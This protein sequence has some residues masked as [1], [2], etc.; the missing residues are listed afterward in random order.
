VHKKSV[1][2]KKTVMETVTSVSGISISS[3]SVALECVTVSNE[4]PGVRVEPSANDSYQSLNTF[5]SSG[6]L[7]FS[8]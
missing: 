8:R 3:S 5:T 7:A 2:Q 1:S 6:K 4:I